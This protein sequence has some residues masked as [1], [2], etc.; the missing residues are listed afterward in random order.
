[1]FEFWH[2]VH[3]PPPYPMARSL[4][5]TFNSSRSPVTQNR[6]WVEVISTILQPSP[7]SD[8][9]QINKHCWQPFVTFC[10]LGD[11]CNVHRLIIILLYGDLRSFLAQ[12]TANTAVGCTM[13]QAMSHF[14]FIWT[15]AHFTIS[16]A[17]QEVVVSQSIQLIKKYRLK[18][19]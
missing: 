12:L 15:W 11:F 9:G 7:E 1:M 6:D 2:H 19:L 8:I 17:G 18:E 16:R 10:E 13:L 5:A 3:T 4:Y 14:G